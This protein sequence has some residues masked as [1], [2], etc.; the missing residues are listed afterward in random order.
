MSAPLVV[1]F[2]GSESD[3]PHAEKI[4]KSCLVCAQ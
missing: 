1:I 2:M 3:L 4:E